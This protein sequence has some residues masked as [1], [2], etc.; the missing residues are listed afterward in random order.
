MTAERRFD[1]ER[2]E[3]KEIRDRHEKSLTQSANFLAYAKTGRM[4][5]T[6]GNDTPIPIP[7]PSEIK[8]MRPQASQLVAD[9]NREFAAAMRKLNNPPE[10]SGEV[11]A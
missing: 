10:E 8:P 3:L 5:F 9:A 11:A 1:E 2:A 7:A 6:D 4:I